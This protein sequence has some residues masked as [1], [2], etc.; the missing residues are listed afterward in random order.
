M[1][2]I[3]TK[4]LKDLWIKFYKDNGHKAIGSASVVPQDDATVLFTSAGMQPLVPYLLGR[5]HP[6]GKLLCNY[7]ACIRTNDIES[8]GDATHLTFFEMLGRWSLGEYFKEDAIKLSY[9]FLTSKEYLGLPLNRL[10]VTVFE[11]DDSLPKDD[12]AASVWEACGMPKDQI[13]YLDKANNWWSLGATGPCGPDSEMFYITDIV[14]ADPN[15][16]P[17]CE[18]GKYVE[19]GND[20]FMSYFQEDGKLTELA[21][22]N[23]DT[24]MG[25]ERNVMVLN[26]LTSVY[27][28]DAFSAP[29][30][31][32]EELSGKIYRDGDDITKAMR[33]IV[34]H[35]RTAAVVLGDINLTT[36][37][38]VGRGY[39]LRRLLRRSVRYCLELGIT[40]NIADALLQIANIYIEKL[41]E[42]YTNLITKRDFILQEIEKEVLKFNKTISAGIKELEKVVSKL[43]GKTLDGKTA[44]RMYDTFGFPIELTEEYLKERNMVVDMV[45]YNSAFEEHQAK[46]RAGS[47]RAF[48]GGLGGNSEII[49]KYHTATHL[50]QAALRQ[51]L[52]NAVSQAGSNITEERLRFDFTF[53]RKV[54]PQEIS[55]VETLVNSW[56]NQGLEVVQ[57]TMP[58]TEAVKMGAI[59]LFNDKYEDVV[60]VYKISDIS[61][62]FCGGPHIANTKEI[63]AFKI[64]KEE[65]SSASVRRI[66]AVI[67]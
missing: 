35:M 5:D 12:F 49:T 10:A 20:V 1:K 3:T 31:K 39:V 32:L 52:G 30:A 61:L 54:T 37:S 7:Q 23:I 29:I 67:N 45:G 25:L 59:G 53:E 34:D 46:S 2:N 41:G 17:A 60:S 26:G 57:L 51:V 38:N 13:F 58:K 14:C 66:K 19:I 33:I 40:E 16:S 47:D 8:V 48:K 6:A 11:G 64:A 36:P 15:C 42:Y 56:I 43:G 55:Q 63:G 9:E 27:E 44:F 4:Q 21:N 28:T 65:S 50:L 18:C 62:E 24:G 22:K